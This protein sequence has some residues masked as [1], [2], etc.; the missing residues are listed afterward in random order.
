MNKGTGA[1]AS[2][3]S[4]ESPFDNCEPKASLFH[5]G[6]L[7][8]NR[9]TGFSS[10]E[11]EKISWLPGA[12]V[13]SQYAVRSTTDDISGHFHGNSMDLEGTDMRLFGDSSTQR[14]RS[15]DTAD[16]RSSSHVETLLDSATAVQQLPAMCY[17]FPN[18]GLGR[19]GNLLS[20]YGSSDAQAGFGVDFLAGMP[21]PTS[22]GGPAVYLPDYLGEVL[23]G[24][25]PA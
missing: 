10:M 17:D 11:L 20:T 18:A 21:F 24:S 3:E 7:S 12:A 22:F 4:R 13:E 16:S 5:Q 1:I 8:T 19:Q 2:E 14:Q 9:I 25:Y 23:S 15:K 6:D